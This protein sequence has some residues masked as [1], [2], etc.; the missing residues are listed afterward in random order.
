MFW[1]IAVLSWWSPTHIN[2]IFAYLG[3][4]RAWIPTHSK[5]LCVAVVC[6]WTLW[7][8][9]YLS[10]S[11][12]A[13]LSS[14]S[15]MNPYWSISELRNRHL[16]IGSCSSRSSYEWRVL[17]CSHSHM[18]LKISQ[19]VLVTNLVSL[20]NVTS[21]IRLFSKVGWFHLCSQYLAL[22]TREWWL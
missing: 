18:L 3:I 9:N 19:E 10:V 22:L 13:W 16:R 20:F 1:T 7:V 12:H 2:L 8:I 11:R 15:S 17:W 4:A 6:I 14:R 21:F 5:H